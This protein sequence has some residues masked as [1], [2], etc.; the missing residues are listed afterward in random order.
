MHL[1]AACSI[2]YCL[3]MLCTIPLGP[4]CWCS[5]R[6]C[7]LDHNF[8]IVDWYGAR[9]PSDQLD[10]C[11]EWLKRPKGRTRRVPTQSSIGSSYSF[12]CSAICRLTCSRDPLFDLRSFAAGEDRSRGLSFA[13]GLRGRFLPR[14]FTLLLG[15]WPPS[16][17]VMTSLVRLCVCTVRRRLDRDVSK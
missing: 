7:H 2:A 8:C 15:R 1:T 9:V 14:C 11:H 6:F 5:C 16:Q 10:V 4:L 3:F 12:I 17:M 13:V